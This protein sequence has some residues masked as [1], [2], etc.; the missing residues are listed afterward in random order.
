MNKQ[1]IDAALAD[2]HEIR[3]YEMPSAMALRN[4][5]RLDRIERV[6]REARESAP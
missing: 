2:L 6:L 3:T 1:E 4:L 5:K